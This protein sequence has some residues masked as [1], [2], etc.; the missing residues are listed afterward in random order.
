MLLDSVLN[1]EATGFLRFAKASL[2]VASAGDTERAA[3]RWESA[4]NFFSES[5]QV[6]FPVGLPPFR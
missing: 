3:G 4:Q 2:R 6:S 1:Q 5:L